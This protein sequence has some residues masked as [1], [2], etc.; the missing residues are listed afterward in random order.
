MENSDVKTINITIAGRIFPVKVTKDEEPVVRNIESDI[1]GKIIDFQNMYP[2]RD[3]L[4]YVIMTLL[5]YIYDI[6]TQQPESAPEEVSAKIETLI[7]ML[8]II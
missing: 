7:Q 3:K 2:T 8:E 5:T 1:N 4:D 6:K